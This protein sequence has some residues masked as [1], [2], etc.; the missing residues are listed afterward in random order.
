MNTASITIIV[1]ADPDLDDCLAGAAKEYLDE[2]PSLRGYE[3]A[4]RWVDE[5]TREH[6]ALTIPQWHA[7][8][9]TPT[10]Y[11]LAVRCRAF[12][13]EGVRQNLLAVDAEGYVTAYDHVAGHYTVCANLSKRAKATARKA[14]AAMRAAAAAAQTVTYRVA[15]AC[16]LPL[17][18][19]EDAHLPEAELVARGLR[20]AQHVGLEHGD[21][22]PV[23]VEDVTV[24]TWTGRI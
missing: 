21:G 14:A 9:N 22:R 24:T 18:S 23:E 6:V 8:E 13:C 20:E 4:P 15:V 7:D 1:P 17:T 16:G 3:L 19:P 10:I 12:S 5:G 2:H 11:G